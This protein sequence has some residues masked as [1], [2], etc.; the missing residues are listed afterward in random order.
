LSH[1]RGS[2][3]SSAIFHAPS[4]TTDAMRHEQRIDVARVAS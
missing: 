4:K 2:P 1:Q 3:R